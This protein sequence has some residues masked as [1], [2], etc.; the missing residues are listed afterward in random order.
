MR[1]LWRLARTLLVANALVL[2]GLAL[3]V[4]WVET[5]CRPTDCQSAYSPVLPHESRRPEA[6][7]L[8]T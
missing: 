2:V 6:D 8:L 4:I 3:H 7:T 1:W 5:L